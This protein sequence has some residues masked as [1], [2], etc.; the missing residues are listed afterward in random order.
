MGKRAQPEH[1]CPGDWKV[2]GWLRAHHGMFHP[3]MHECGREEG[4]RGRC[5]CRFCGSTHAN[6]AASRTF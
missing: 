1:V 5:R 4:H 6:P 3:S 2:R